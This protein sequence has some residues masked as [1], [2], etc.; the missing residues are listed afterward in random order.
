MKRIYIAGPYTSGDVAVNV[1]NAMTAGL[2]IAKAG[3]APF[4]P[5]LYHFMHLLEPQSYATWTE[6]DLAWID[7][8]DYF[9]RLP[10]DSP[11]SEA[12]E[13]RAAYRGLPI[14]YDMKKLLEFLK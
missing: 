2:A 11:G 13:I 7:A 3:H 12:E 8:C 1:R 6:L 5:H 14:F 9:F 4:V 10:G